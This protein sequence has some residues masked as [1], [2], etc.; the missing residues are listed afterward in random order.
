MKIDPHG[1]F[2]MILTFLSVAVLI[3]L[4]VVLIGATVYTAFE[5]DSTS[6]LLALVIIAIGLSVAW[7]D[8]S[9]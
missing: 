4:G 5:L 7:L 3:T 8:Y 1:A 9:K 2:G 6:A